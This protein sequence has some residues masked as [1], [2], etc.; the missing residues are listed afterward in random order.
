[1]AVAVHLRHVESSEVRAIVIVLGVRWS[2]MSDKRLVVAVDEI[3]IAKCRYK[4]YVGLEPD[5]P[6]QGNMT[7]SRMSLFYSITMLRT[8]GSVPIGRHSKMATG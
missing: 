6:T 8:C 5:D 3:E 1:M 2:S 4:I 7:S